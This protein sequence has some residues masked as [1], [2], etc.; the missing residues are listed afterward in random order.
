[1]KSTRRICAVLMKNEKLLPLLTLCLLFIFLGA[2]PVSA[3]QTSGSCGSNLTW[4][5]DEATGTLMISGQGEMTGGPTYDY[6]VYTKNITKVVIGEGV[7]SIG[8]HAFSGHRKI[9]SVSLPSTLRTIGEYAFSGCDMLT[10]I[11]L[12]NVTTIKDLAFTSCSLTE[13][14]IPVTLRSLGHGAFSGCM[15]LTKVTI[16]G[17]LTKIGSDAFRL[18]TALTSIHIPEG[19]TTIGNGAFSSTG[20]TEITLPDSLTTLGSNAFSGCPNL[21][22]IRIPDNV[23]AINGYTFSSCTALTEVILG[24][25]VQEVSNSAFQNCSVLTAVSVSN[26]NRYICA[27]DRGVLYNKSK[28][29]LLLFPFGISGKYVVQPGTVRI[30]PWAAFSLKQLTEIV[31]PEGLTTIGRS[32]FSWCQNLE[33]VTLP[34]SLKTIEVEAF[35]TTSIF[36]ITFPSSLTKIDALAFD[37]CDKLC[38]ITFLG[39]APQICDDAFRGVVAVSTT[40]PCSKNWS[41]ILGKDGLYIQYGGHLN[42]VSSDY[43]PVTV[44]GKE[45]TCAA[46]GYSESTVCGTC[47]KVAV[48]PT[49]YP[50]ESHDY[51]IQ[52]VLDER[53]HRLTCADCGHT[54]TGSHSITAK[55]L[56]KSTCTTPGSKLHSCLECDY[57]LTESLPVD[58]KGHVYDHGC[59][60]DCNECGTK[61]E[62]KHVFGKEWNADAAGHWRICLVCQSREETAAH[63]PGPEATSAAGQTCTVCK[64]EMAPPLSN[65]TEP[66]TPSETPIPSAS[67]PW[68]SIPAGLSVVC[69]A[70]FVLRRKKR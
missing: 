8:D 66:T 32:A 16:P 22:K 67:F 17:T 11:D 49:F 44:P 37:Q 1:M 43:V 27:D 30:A 18:A 52:E 26:E 40:Y 54:V 36:R 45:A 68:W 61:R 7:T 58:E 63:T 70:G 48:P 41:N 24:K 19:V 5:F 38:Y 31:F 13:L 69:I 59:D 55:V 47:G 3:T 6:H 29:E 50:K 9:S 42:W 23:T 4:Q 20:L 15:Y 56:K 10:E 57:E 12:K 33:K 64:Y 25:G 62:T 35:N 34:E 28:T 39:N 60:P 51:A 2:H 65:S 14:T 46:S 53:T 21:K